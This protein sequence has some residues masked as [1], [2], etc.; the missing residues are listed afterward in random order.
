MND[1][2]LKLGTLLSV[3]YIGERASKSYQG[4]FKND[5]DWQFGR[6]RKRMMEE[7]EL[8]SPCG[9]IENEQDTED[10]AEDKEAEQDDLDDARDRIEVLIDLLAILPSVFP[11]EPVVSCLSHSD[12]GLQN[13]LTDSNGQITGIID[14]EFVSILPLWAACQ[15][16]KFLRGPR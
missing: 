7:I 14:W 11:L 13:I 8:L 6:V 5:Y 10:E 4:P 15:L 2:P 9:E 12:L 16:P 3:D 1:P